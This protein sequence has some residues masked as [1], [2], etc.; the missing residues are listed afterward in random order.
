MCEHVIVISGLLSIS[1]GWVSGNS[2]LSFRP[3][4]HVVIQE[5]PGRDIRKTVLLSRL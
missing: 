2:L 3:V 5:A 4:E 1:T